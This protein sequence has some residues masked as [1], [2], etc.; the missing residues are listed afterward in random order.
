MVKV[1][2]SDSPDAGHTNMKAVVL[3]RD[4]GKE[5]TP[6]VGLTYPPDNYI[7]VNNFDLPTQKDLVSL[8]ILADHGGV[9]CAT[10]AD[11]LKIHKGNGAHDI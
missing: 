9:C 11:F 4:A 3:K 7:G 2:D 5:K 10:A 6:Q 1:N 8:R